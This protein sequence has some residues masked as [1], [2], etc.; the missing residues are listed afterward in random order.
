LPT[1]AWL[2]I[3]CEVGNGIGGR[4]LCSPWVLEIPLYFSVEMYAYRILNK[5]PPPHIYIFVESYPPP[6]I[7]NYCPPWKIF[8]GPPLLLILKTETKI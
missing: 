2:V 6:D 5:C 1:A 7:F 3:N 8:L 4:R